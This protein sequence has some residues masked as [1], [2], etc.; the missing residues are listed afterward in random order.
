[1]LT[2]VHNEFLQTFKIR[3]MNTII[4]DVRSKREFSEATYP[5][6]VN[7]PS[8]D[9]DIQRFERFRDNHIALLCNS[10]SRAEKVQKKLL[11]A[12]FK[13]VSLLEIHMDHLSTATETVDT[14]WTVD[15]Q[16]RLVMGVFIGVG[17]LMNL[18]VNVEVSIVL[19]S[20]LFC[21][22]TYSS[23][24]DTCYLKQLIAA[25]PWNEQP[26]CTPNTARS[27]S[28]LLAQ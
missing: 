20:V 28:A 2:S 9:F 1:M 11:N 23:I 3:A 26:T 10:G 22:L 13:S 25:M 21:G 12:G 18:F 14:R 15:R 24:T 8:S 16:F 19:L 4:I 27:G 6:A 5:G 7:V 17:I